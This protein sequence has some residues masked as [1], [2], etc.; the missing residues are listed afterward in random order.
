MTA[1]PCPSAR[2]VRASTTRVLPLAVTLGSSAAS[3][4]AAP[5]SAACRCASGPA[6]RMFARAPAPHSAAWMPSAFS[7]STSMGTTEAAFAAF[8]SEPAVMFMSAPAAYSLAMLSP[9]LS[10]LTR[11]SSEPPFA[12]CSLTSG[13]RQERFMMPSAASAT[14]SFSSAIRGSPAPACQTASQGPSSAA[15]I[16]SAWAD[17]RFASS[18]R[19][20]IFRMAISAGIMSGASAK[21]LCTFALWSLKRFASA[22]AARSFTASSGSL[23]TVASG[24]RAPAST[25]RSL[26]FG[27]GARF[28]ISAAAL[29]RTSTSGSL[30]RPTDFLV[31]CAL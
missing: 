14:P 28:M 5:A 10:I 7:S 31:T 1:G 23:R 25:I 16:A 22:P 13:Q 21:P 17:C 9:V 4:V 27:C 29:R 6:R 26:I 18:V 15:S 30:S 8:S 19:P 24:F 20:F 11:S 3:S 12:S 2:E